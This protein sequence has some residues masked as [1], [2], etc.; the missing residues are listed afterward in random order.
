MSDFLFLELIHTLC[1][2][3]Q[4]EPNYEADESVLKVA[5]DYGMASG[6]LKSR[7]RVVVCQK[8]GDTSVVK[9]IEL[10]D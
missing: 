8:I 10:E 6:V 4:D 9:I 3:F 1:M 2:K 5:T 7:D